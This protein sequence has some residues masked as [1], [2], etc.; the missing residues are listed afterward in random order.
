MEE[1]EKKSAEEAAVVAPKYSLSWADE[2]NDG[3]QDGEWGLATSSKKKKNKKGK[4]S[5]RY[6]I[7][8]AENPL[9]IISSP[10]PHQLP[11]PIRVP[12]KRFNWMT[13]LRS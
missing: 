10:S 12:S 2:I 8:A 1:E 6:Q 7:V 3:K 11:S 9:I 4:V 5:Y 13:T